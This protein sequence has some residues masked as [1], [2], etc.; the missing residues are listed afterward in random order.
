MCV[1]Y[2]SWIQWLF[3]A[4]APF[5]GGRYTYIISGVGH[6]R[7]NSIMPLVLSLLCMVM[8]NGRGTNIVL[9]VPWDSANVKWCINEDNTPF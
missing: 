5:K 9:Q 4:G 6:P 8:Y 7:S 3:V 1:L 2:G